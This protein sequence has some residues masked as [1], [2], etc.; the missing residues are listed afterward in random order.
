MVMSSVVRLK[1]RPALRA[2]AFAPLM[3][4]FPVCSNFVFTSKRA[5]RAKVLTRFR[6]RSHGCLTNV[7]CNFLLGTELELVMHHGTES[8]LIAMHPA[9]RDEILVHEP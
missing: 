1:G 5:V 4:L 6:D 3:S 9:T 7:I 8:P 2:R